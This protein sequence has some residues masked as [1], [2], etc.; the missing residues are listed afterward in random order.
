MSVENNNLKQFK[1]NILFASHDHEFIQTVANRI[2]ELT[3]NGVID[4]LMEY[5]EYMENEDV[6][7]FYAKKFI[8]GIFEEYG[9]I[10]I[11]SCKKTQQWE[12]NCTCYRVFCGIF[13]DIRSFYVFQKRNS[14][15]FFNG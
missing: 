6:L 10:H 1:G 14:G 15:L 12:N 2:I 4:K 7:N 5:D 11:Y 13:T 3:P 9:I 8:D